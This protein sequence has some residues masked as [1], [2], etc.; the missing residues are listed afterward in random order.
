M[1]LDAEPNNKHVLI[2]CNL[3]ARHTESLSQLSIE[4]QSMNDIKAL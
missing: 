4:L 2:Q 3:K 1:S